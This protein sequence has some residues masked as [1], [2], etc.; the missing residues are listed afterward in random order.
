QELMAEFPEVYRQELAL[1]NASRDEL[2]SQIDIARQ[3]LRQKERELQEGRASYSQ[4]DR[5][6]Q[7]SVK[8]LEVT[9][10]LLA[11]GAVS[12]VD[13]L[14]LERDASRL[15]GE[16]EQAGAQIGRVQS[17]IAEARRKIAEVEQAQLSKIRTDLNETTGKLNAL[18]ATSQGLSDKVN[19]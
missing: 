10:P 16:R 2:A 14:R 9:K 11:S 12:D 18:M 17:A 13:I 5:G 6:Y 15:L 3:Q 8:G 4:A 7:L 1:Y 19:Q